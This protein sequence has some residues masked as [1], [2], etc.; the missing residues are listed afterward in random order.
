MVHLSF[1]A[2]EWIGLEKANAHSFST[3]LDLLIPYARSTL[4]GL[5]NWVLYWYVCMVWYA[6]NTA[7]FVWYGAVWY[8]LVWI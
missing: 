3:F 7:W 8:L 5:L 1:A 6:W 2:P 4:D